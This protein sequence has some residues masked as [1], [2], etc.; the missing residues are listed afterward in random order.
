MNLVLGA[1]LTMVALLALGVVVA[2]DR[3][4]VPV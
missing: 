3:D 1:L 4:P 2:T